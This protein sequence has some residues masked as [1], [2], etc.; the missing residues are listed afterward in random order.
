VR[1]EIIITAD[2][3]HSISIPRMN[4]TYHS[5]HGAIQ[6]SKH[7][8]IEAG[9]KALTPAETKLSIFE[10][11]FG[12]GLNVLLSL[13]EA[14]RSEKEIYYETV[15]QF[16]LDTNETGQLNYCNQLGR[17]DLQSIFDKLHSCEWEK[18]IK[19]APGF[20]FKKSKINLSTYET[21]ETF[22]LVFFDA[23]APNVQPELWTKE[24]F[25]KMFAMLQPGGILVTYCSKGDAR[26]AMQAAGFI[27]EKLP[28]PKGKREMVRCKTRIDRI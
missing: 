27:V 10:V 2:G 13:I 1:K 21:S 12:T 3:S 11:G 15:E 17:Q 8:F 19:L 9:L 18:E 6:E 23:F 5:V 28:G 16:P 4:V 26:R 25:E 14:E 24:T 20:T 22:D 7:V